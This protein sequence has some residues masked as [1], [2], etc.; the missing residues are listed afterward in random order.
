MDPQDRGQLTVGNVAPDEHHAVAHLLAR[1]FADEALFAYL[2]G[3]ESDERV[4]ALDPFMR[5]MVSGHAPFSE[6]HGAWIDGRLTGASIRIRPGHFPLRGRDLLHLVPR[7]VPGF[8][9]MCLRKTRARRLLSAVTALEEHHP[10]GKPYWYFA[11]VGVD[12]DFRLRG[13][14]S[15]LAEIVIRRADAEGHGCYLDTF[16]QATKALYERRGFRV[17]ADL[18]PFPDGPSGWGLWRDPASSSDHAR[19]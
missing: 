11:F 18:K 17:H 7:A 9:R 6:I 12:P 19:G 16:G 5:G 10:R 15:N 13:I 2:L 4:R 1:A 3:G 14:A 8:L